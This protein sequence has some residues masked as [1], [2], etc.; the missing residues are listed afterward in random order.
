VAMPPP[1]QSAAPAEKGGLANI[2]WSK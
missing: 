1:P 2:D